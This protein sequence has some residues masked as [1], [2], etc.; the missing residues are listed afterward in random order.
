MM[1]NSSVFGVTY[2]DIEV[3]VYRFS[4]MIEMKG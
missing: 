2:H 1:W 4:W 3:F